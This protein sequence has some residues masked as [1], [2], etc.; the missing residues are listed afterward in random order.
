LENGDRA[1]CLDS[2]ITILREVFRAVS[3][4]IERTTDSR[5]TA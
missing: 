4:T 2:W 3:P 5:H 1:L